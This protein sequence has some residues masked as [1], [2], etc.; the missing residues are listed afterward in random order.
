MCYC[1]TV[2]VTDTRSR[3]PLQKSL[4]KDRRSGFGMQQGARVGPVEPD[5]AADILQNFPLL[6]NISCTP[7]I[8]SPCCRYFQLSARHCRPGR[9]RERIVRQGAGL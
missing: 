7:A 5:I 9:C 8:L 2:V 6:C 4:D 1:I 3:T